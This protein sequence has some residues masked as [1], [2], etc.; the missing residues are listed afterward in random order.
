MRRRGSRKV[1]GKEGDM[2]LSIGFKMSPAAA[3]SAVVMK[4]GCSY[5]TEPCLDPPLYITQAFMN[6]SSLHQLSNQKSL[7]SPLTA[8]GTWLS[9]S[10]MTIVYKND[11]CRLWKELRLYHSF[12]EG[13]MLF[14]CYSG[15]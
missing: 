4:V 13:N 14:I 7:A 5:V 12:D 6:W 15:E 2:P 1:N 11:A 3:P 10:S 9:A 8:A